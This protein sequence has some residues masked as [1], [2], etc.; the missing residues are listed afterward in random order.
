MAVGFGFAGMRGR[1][2][3]G[4][5]IAVKA[6]SERRPGGL[7]LVAFMLEELRRLSD[8]PVPRVIHAGEHLL[9]MSWIDHDGGGLT[10]AGERQAAELLAD[11]HARRFERFGYRRDTVIGS[12]L[13]PNGEM[14]SWVAFFAGRRLM[15]MATRAHGEGALPDRLMSRLER[16]AERLGEF[17]TEPDHPALIH[18]DVWGG[19]V[20]ARGGHVAGFVD[21]AIYVAH[22]EIEL[23]FTTMF[24]TFGTAFFDAYEALAPL[25]PGF[26]DTRRRIYNLYPALVHLRLFGTGY[27]RPIEDTLRRIGM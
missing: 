12:L 16:L 1:L 6:D 17:L 13:Q 10:A 22:P 27:L 4:R 19:N 5:R 2:E 3:D 9:I 23:A 14:E 26:H 25:E 11:L 24:G 18:G 8:L 21:P 15:H 20:L 7:A